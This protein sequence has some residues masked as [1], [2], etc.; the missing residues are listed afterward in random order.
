MKNRLSS[1]PIYQRAIAKVHLGSC[2]SDQ[3]KLDRPIIAIV[4]SWNELVT[5]HV[6]FRTLADQ[7]KESILAAGGFPL[8][9]NTIAICDGIAQGHAGMKYVL[10]SRE[11]I[12][13]SIE[14]MILGHGMFDGMVMLGSCDKIVPGMLMAAA[15]INIPTIMITG[16]PMQHEI[17][18]KENKDARQQFIRGDITEEKLLEVSKK[19]YTRAGVCP[20]LGTANTM[21]VIAE[22][23]GMTLPGVSVTPALSNEQ[24]E[25]VYE[26][27]KTILNLVQHNIKPR[28]IMTEKAFKNAITMTLAMGGSLNSTLHIPAIAAECGL[29]VTVQDFDRISRTTPLN[30]R[31]CPNSK[32]FATAD[33]YKVGGTKTIMHELKS[34]L[35]L[36]VT[37]VNGKTL[38]EN[39]TNALPA[40]G[41]I[42]RSVQQPFE[43]EGGIAVLYGSLAPKGAVVKSSAVPK[44]E[45]RFEGPAMVFD[46]EED[47]TEAFYQQKIESGTAVIIRNEGPCGGPGMREM[48][49]AT[50]LLA[51]IPNIAIITDGRFSGA[52]AGLSVGYLS[53]EAY[54]GGPIGLVENGD[55]IKIDIEK[56]SIDWCIA[57]EIAETRKKAFVPHQAEVSSNF[58]RMYRTMTLDAANGAVRKTFE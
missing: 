13:D 10:A 3:S 14:A 54:V 39:I 24:K 43:P 16:G 52:S 28:D 7:V 51:K 27:G 1:F 32:E 38:G 34:L 6:H 53:P 22:A 35:H 40:D 19:Y 58:L 41:D 25:L 8:E 11:L 31:V 49:R 18:P 47:C 42:I 37:T 46:C 56:R 5:G 48:H 15:R 4:N 55:L 17:T 29:T 26:T 9:F 30:T 23:L 57:E 33:L 20:F 44:E 50:E 21:C 36:D 2:G 12:A 45:W